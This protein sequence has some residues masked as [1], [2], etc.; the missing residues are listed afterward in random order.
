M[1][2]IDIKDTLLCSKTPCYISSD[3]SG[4]LSNP[5][6]LIQPMKMLRDYNEEAYTIYETIDKTT[7]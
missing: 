5:G 3:G 6:K 7:V 1:I 2:Y 4:Y